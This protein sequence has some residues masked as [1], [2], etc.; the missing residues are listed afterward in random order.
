[1]KL[2]AKVGAGGTAQ[3]KLGAWRTLLK[4]CAEAR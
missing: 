3:K 4:E 1:M 2:F